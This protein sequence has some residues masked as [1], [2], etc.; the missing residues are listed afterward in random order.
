MEEM[1]ERLCTF[2][3]TANPNNNNYINWE[4]GYKKTLIL[5]DNETK[6]SK[7]NSFKLWYTMFTNKAPGE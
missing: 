7:P 5:G 2:C 4:S 1:T 6:L 3:L